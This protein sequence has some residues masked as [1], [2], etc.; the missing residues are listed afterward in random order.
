MECLLP[1]G[2]GF[3]DKEKEQAMTGGLGPS[4]LICNNQ[5]TDKSWKNMIRLAVSFYAYVTL[6]QGQG[7][8]TWCK[9]LLKTQLKVEQYLW[10]QHFLLDHKN[11]CVKLK[12]RKKFT[13]SAKTPLG[14]TTP[15]VYLTWRPLSHCLVNC[16]ISN[17][18]GQCKS[19]SLPL[20][21][22]LSALLSSAT[23]E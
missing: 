5:C 16:V 11:P 8:K 18:H 19:C 14:L 10:K 13:R 22:T 9:G 12:K 17:S 3:R 20:P 1:G 6:K 23:Q 7:H 15:T 21:S 4:G 2:L